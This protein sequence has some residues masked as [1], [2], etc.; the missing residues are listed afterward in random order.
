M[1]ANT[2]LYSIQYSALRKN[3]NVLKFRCTLN[4]DKKI[5]KVSITSTGVNHTQVQSR[6]KCDDLSIRCQSFTVE[7]KFKC[8]KEQSQYLSCQGLSVH[9]QPFPTMPP[10]MQANGA[11]SV[12]GLIE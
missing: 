5:F 4:K 1:K 12:M 3:S 9:L 7:I 2:K 10:Y 11:L 6:Y 8:S